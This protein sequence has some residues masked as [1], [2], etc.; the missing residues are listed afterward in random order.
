MGIPRSVHV[1]HHL[2]I[3]MKMT[4]NRS[5][6]KHAEKERESDAIMST[7]LRI[8]QLTFQTFSIEKKYNI[9]THAA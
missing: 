9:F 1:C 2:T 4:A 3:T 8:E 5:E 6:K 7:M